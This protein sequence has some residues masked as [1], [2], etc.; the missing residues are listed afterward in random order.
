MFPPSSGVC[1]YEARY[2]C[3][4]DYCG[5]I[6]ICISFGLLRFVGDCG[7]MN[8]VLDVCACFVLFVSYV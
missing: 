5:C 8:I 2:L 4:N 1:E 7:W 6:K 3:L